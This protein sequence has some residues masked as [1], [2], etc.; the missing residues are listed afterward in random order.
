MAIIVLNEFDSNGIHVQLKHVL[1]ETESYVA[2]LWVVGDT[3]PTFLSD[4]VQDG[5]K[6]GR[7]SILPPE[8]GQKSFGSKTAA[9][10]WIRKQL[11]NSTFVLLS[12]KVVD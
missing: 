2:T 11:D 10:R 7:I 4:V 3:E 6:V 8:L 5:K 12:N 1:W 9:E